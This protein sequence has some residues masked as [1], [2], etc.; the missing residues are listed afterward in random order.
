MRVKQSDLNSRNS[1]RV[2]THHGKLVVAAVYTGL[3]VVFVT[4]TLMVRPFLQGS[5]QPNN[6]T[7]YS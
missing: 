6:V 4:V 2:T 5:N 3:S 1:R 7:G